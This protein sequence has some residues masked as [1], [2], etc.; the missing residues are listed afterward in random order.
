MSL[1]YE[2]ELYLF[3]YQIT[4]S[5]TPELFILGHDN[6]ADYKIIDRNKQKNDVNN[7]DTPHH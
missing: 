4:T 5:K 7:V 1:Q 3:R 6:N 2:M